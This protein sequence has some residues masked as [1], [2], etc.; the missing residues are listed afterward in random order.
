MVVPR[1]QFLFAFVSLDCSLALNCSFCMEGLLGRTRLSII[2]RFLAHTESLALARLIALAGL[3]CRTGL[4]CGT[5]LLC[6]TGLLCHT[7]LLCRTGLL[8]HTGLHDYARLRRS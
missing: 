7:G 1:P 6:R 4:L 5:G 2:A 3:L 8:C